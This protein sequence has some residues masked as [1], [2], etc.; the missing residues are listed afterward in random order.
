MKL[1]SRLEDYTEDEFMTLL[2]TLFNG[3]SD[4]EAD[5]QSLVD[6][7]DKMIQHPRG[8]GILFYPD[9]G[10]DDSPEGVIGVVKAWRAA[11]GLPGFKSG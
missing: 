7:I 9:E 6:H 8:N 3:E 2:N 4:T 10:V 11:N 1:K 5:Y